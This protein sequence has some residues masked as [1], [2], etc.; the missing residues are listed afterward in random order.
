MPCI[1]TDPN[2]VK[3]CVLLYTQNNRITLW[4][5]KSARLFRSLHVSLPIGLNIFGSVECVPVL[6]QAES[7]T[8]QPK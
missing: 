2:V 8:A 7:I 6:T 1:A 5:D 4:N 3:M